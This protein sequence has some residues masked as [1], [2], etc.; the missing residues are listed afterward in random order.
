M[1]YRIRASLFAAL[2]GLTLLP[3]TEVAAH[4]VSLD[5]YHPLPAQ[6]AFHR[7]FLIPWTQ[8]VEQESGGRMRFHLHAA[9]PAGEGLYQKAEEGTADIIWTPIQ[10]SGQRFPRLAVMEIPFMTRTAQGGSRAVSE[11]ARVNDLL[12]RDFDGVRVLAVHVADGSQLHWGKALV[13]PPADIAGRRIAAVTLVDAALLAAM[14]A[15]PMAMQPDAVAQALDEDAVDGALLGWERAGATGV[16]R[17]TRSH[18]E[19]GRGNPGVTTSLFVFAMSAGS[20]RAL[21][22]DLKKIIDANSGKETAAWLGRVLDEAGGEVRKAALARGDAIRTIEPAARE[23]WAQA[24][25]SV[26]EAQAKVLE[27]VDIRLKPLLDSAREQLQEFDP[28]R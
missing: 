19:V 26:T 14:G 27:Q 10:A 11:Y 20:Y 25:R 6:S 2:L 8:K 7:A 22:D 9:A 16:D 24:A 28:S 3:G 12:D 23:R 21:A 17:V 18:V 5:V 15:T 13:D 1:R 4:G